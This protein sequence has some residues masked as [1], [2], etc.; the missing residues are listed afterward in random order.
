VAYARTVVDKQYTAAKR[1]Y[2]IDAPKRSLT[3]PLTRRKA[4]ISYAAYNQKRSRTELSTPHDELTK[5]RDVTEPPDAQ[6][7]L[8]WWLLH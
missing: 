5:Y 7:P 2:N 6:D 8:E 3:S 4:L 1:L